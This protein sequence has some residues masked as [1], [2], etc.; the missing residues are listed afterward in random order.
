M[1]LVIKSLR[2]DSGD[3]AP[4]SDI[5]FSYEPNAIS[6]PQGAFSKDCSNLVVKNYYQNLLKDVMTLQNI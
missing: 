3:A 6:S 4:P 1:K 2:K 5:I